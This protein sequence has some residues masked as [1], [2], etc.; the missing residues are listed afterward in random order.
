MKYLFW[1]FI[2]LLIT[3]R[4]HLSL[5][6]FQD[7]DTVKIIT[8]V[9][10]EPLIFGQQ[11]YLKILGLK[12]Y[13]P[14][15]P[16]VTYG[17]RVE[18]VGTIFN[19]KLQ[20]TNFKLLE[21]QNNFLFKFRNKIITFY[22]IS[23]PEP[24]SSLLAG[25]TLGSKQMPEEFWDKLRTTGTAHIVVASGTNVTMLASFLIGTLTYYFKRKTAIFIT[26]AGILCYV[27]LSGLDAPIVRAA[28]MGIILLFGQV[29]GRVT[30]TWRILV[31]TIVS[32][33]LW[34]PNWVTDLGFILSFVATV[35]LLL[36]Q[37]RID[38]HLTRIP[39]LFREGFSTSIAAQIGVAPIIFAS[40]GQFNILSPVINALVLWTIPYIM[41]L[42]MIAGV[43]GI[44]VPLVGR[45]ILFVIYPI[46]YFFE[47]VV[48]IFSW[49]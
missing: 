20:I 2:I 10:S 35:S 27:F 16:E 31:Y 24:Y 5:P 38:G 32:M 8:Q 25:I 1:L 28:I 29:T 15:Y 42:G 33:L 41:S 36:F 26:I 3:V 12:V 49:T 4:Y 7:G 47:Q 23:L 18:I 45:L 22:K 34:K 6:K 21:Q 37:K 39:K 40:F 14:R 9:L 19:S 17:D 44:T 46:L 30:D 43:I 11:Q 13:L 48:T